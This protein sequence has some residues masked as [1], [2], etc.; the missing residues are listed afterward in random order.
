MSGA[1]DGTHRTGVT[2]A[3]IWLG[4]IVMLTATGF[5]GLAQTA[6]TPVLSTVATHFGG[7]GHGALTAQSIATMSAVGVMF[8][9]PIVGLISEWIGA[10]RLLFV[11]LAIYAIAGSAGLYLDGITPL[12]ASRLLQGVGS[13]GITISTAAM[14]GDRFQG[15]ERPKFLG[16]QGAFLAAAGFISLLVSGQAAEI[17]G[18]R[19]PFALFL[20]ALPMLALA[21]LS[22]DSDPPPKT[23]ANTQ[24]PGESS[25][26]S[27]WPIYLAVILI[28]TAGYM[29]YLQLS[30]VLAGDHI[31]SPALQSRIVSA[32]TV[33]H[34]V[35]GLLYG[36]TIEKL[37]ARWMLFL[38]LLGMAVSDFIIGFTTFVPAVVVACGVAG[39]A[40]GNLVIYVTNLILDRAKPDIRGKALGLM[41]M[42][43][44]VGDFLNPWLATPLRLAIGNHN[45]FIAVGGLLLVTAVG[46]VIVFKP[47]RLARAQPA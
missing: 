27:M 3:R 18:W 42:A 10:R 32:S 13:A 28:Y 33:M 34:F 35:G 47:A 8:G 19:A 5:N 20:T 29:I 15:T 22:L 36:K 9:G 38:I 4:T 45:A 14:I 31:T 23:Q 21:V 26:W 39:L 11:A 24:A 17:M 30:F 37:G 2:S 1:A 25:I 43:M 46:Q 40:G 7:G 16:Y 44:Y 6:F 12:L 41:V